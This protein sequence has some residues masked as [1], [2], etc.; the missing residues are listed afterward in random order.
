MSLTPWTEGTVRPAGHL[1]YIILTVLF[2][3]IMPFVLFFFFFC[4]YCVIIVLHVK[5][6][7]KTIFKSRKLTELE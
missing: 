3:I 6:L 1:R 2:K 7:I 4:F 5:S